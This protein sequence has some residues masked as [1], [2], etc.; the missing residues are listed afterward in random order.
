MSSQDRN[1]YDEFIARTVSTRIKICSKRSFR[2]Y[3][4]LK[5]VK[6]VEKSNSIR[7]L[8]MKYNVY[9]SSIQ[10]WIKNKDKLVATLHKYRKTDQS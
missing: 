8:A 9:R 10:G 3:H 6:L 2:V 5:I 7:S 4:K 1:L